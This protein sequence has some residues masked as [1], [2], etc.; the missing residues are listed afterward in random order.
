MAGLAGD[1]AHIVEDWVRASKLGSL[2]KVDYSAKEVEVIHC[3]SVF[4]VRDVWKLASF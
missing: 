1:V 4:L 3:K 2:F